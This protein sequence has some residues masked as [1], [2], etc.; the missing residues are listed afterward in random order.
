MPHTTLPARGEHLQ[1]LCHL[2]LLSSELR[3][4]L[5][6]LV[7]TL[8][9]RAVRG[10]MRDPRPGAE[11]LAGLRRLHSGQHD[12]KYYSGSWARF[13]VGPTLALPPARASCTYLSPMCFYSS[14]SFRFVPSQ[15]AMHG[16]GSPRVS[17]LQLGSPRPQL[18]TLRH[19]VPSPR[20]ISARQGVRTSR[21]IS[22]TPHSLRQPSSLLPTAPPS[23][24]TPGRASA[25]R[26][27]SSYQPSDAPWRDPGD[28][29]WQSFKKSL[30]ERVVAPVRPEL[31]SR[32]I[33]EPIW[34]QPPLV[35]R[36][37]TPS[38]SRSPVTRLL[39]PLDRDATCQCGM[40]HQTTSSRTVSE[41]LGSLRKPHA[42]DQLGLLECDLSRGTTSRAKA[43]GRARAAQLAE[44][45]ARDIGPESWAQS[46]ARGL[47][48]RCDEFT[49]PAQQ[50]ELLELTDADLFPHRSTV[51]EGLRELAEQV[52]SQCEER[53]LLVE[54]MRRH[55]IDSLQVSMELLRILQGT[56]R[57][58]K[59][60]RAAT[61]A[62]LMQS[63]QG[64]LGETMRSMQPTERP[65]EDPP[66][67]APHTDHFAGSR[68]SLA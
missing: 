43:A 48:G 58:N 13:A 20:S 67:S 44:T 3:T 65:T 29:S 15:V 53:G 22:T 59:Q 25:S 26:C 19:D 30:G 11:G 17:A 40:D 56:L 12:Q 37:D 64:F 2:S 68:T 63:F 49:L 24:A 23:R 33:N 51:D 7:V 52:G 66:V 10:R 32:K 50:D 1:Q 14:R 36:Y 39:F 60:L 61:D 8:I 35:S 38:A 54:Y 27:A 46:R 45:L 62:G 55:Y 18:H 5:Q 34:A 47:F 4:Q 28:L 6:N 42:V 16:V 57:T 41:R 21:T 9:T 31:P